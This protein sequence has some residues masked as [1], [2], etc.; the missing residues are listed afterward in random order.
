MMMA[1]MTMM[2]PAVVDD[3]TFDRRAFTEMVMMEY[4]RAGEIQL[5]TNVRDACN[6]QT[7]APGHGNCSYVREGK[8]NCVA[9]NCCH[10]YGR[11][12]DM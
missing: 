1:M 9:S 2:G 11:S 8:I 4:R 6:F 10:A 12:Q 3:E 5:Y 7:V